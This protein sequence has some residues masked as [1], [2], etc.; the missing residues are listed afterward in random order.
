MQK[1]TKIIIG[2]SSIL[3]IGFSIFLIAKYSK[4][5]P[6]R[7]SKSKSKV[8]SLNPEVEDKELSEKFNFHL[9]PDGKNNYRSAQFTIKELPEVIKKYGIKNII[10][11]NGDGTDS[12]HKA[13]YGQTPKSEE[14]RICNELGCKFYFIN[15][16]S[17]YKSGQGYIG[18]INEVLP[19]LNQ[20]NTL[21]HCAHGADRTGYLVATHLQ[22]QNI[23]T[24]KDDLWSYT[25]QF[26]RW[27]KM[28]DKDT[29]FGSGYDKYAD[30]FYPIN[31]LSN[32][33]WV[34]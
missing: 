17:G 21:I 29:F 24:N 28:V 1:R 3:V 32:S 9:I 10:R 15:A 11:L 30:G 20:G 33:K 12:Q 6:N 7:K 26:N 4:A 16:H 25:T 13:S 2:I 31:E 27:Q 5:N 8:D 19:I 22:K 34:K 23:M 14:E 18:T